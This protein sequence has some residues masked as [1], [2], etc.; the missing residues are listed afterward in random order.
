MTVGPGAFA[1]A[2]IKYGTDE[3]LET[4]LWGHGV[5]AEREVFRHSVKM[6]NKTYLFLGLRVFIIIL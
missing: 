3:S 4:V 6:K 5:T 1:F 2:N